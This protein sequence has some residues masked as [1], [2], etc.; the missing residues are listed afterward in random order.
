MNSSPTPENDAGILFLRLE[1]PLQS[2]GDR[3]I[4]RSRGTALIPTKSGLVGLLGAALGL[5]RAAL[6]RRLDELN[7]LAMAVRVDRAGHVA[8]DYQTVGARIGVVAADGHVKKTASTG[9]YEAI[10]SPRDYLVDASFLVLLRGNLATIEEL[11]DAL[12]NPRW[13]LY[14]GRKRCVPGARVFAGSETGL[15]LADAIRQDGPDDDSLREPDNSRSV[16]VV[17]DLIDQ[18]AFGSLVVCEGNDLATRY[19][20]AKSYLHDR[21]VQLAPPV[22]GA[23]SCWTLRCR[24]RVRRC[25]GQNLPIRCSEFRHLV[26]RNAPAIPMLAKPLEP[27]R[28]AAASSAATN[29][30]PR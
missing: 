12:R 1:G 28:R 21:L 27:N 6:N 26:G 30:R 3:A 22:H 29:R 20:A 15:A 4:G 10:I 11:A 17:S 19:A 23:G 9:E 8:E 2:W 14:L 5:S 13:P 24:G 25:S 16:R 7:S 18:N